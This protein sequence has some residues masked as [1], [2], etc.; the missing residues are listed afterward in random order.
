[1]RSKENNRHT[2]GNGMTELD[3]LYNELSNSITNIS[4][5][6]LDINLDEFNLDQASKGTIV[7]MIDTLKRDIK[8]LQ[9]DLDRIKKRHVKIKPNGG[10]PL[11][12]AAL[13]FNLGSRYTEMSDKILSTLPSLCQDIIFLIQQ[14]STKS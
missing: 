10:D 6:V 5:P 3:K 1:M 11:D 7:S 2:N 9:V 8:N 4:K 12:T 13:Y 14:K